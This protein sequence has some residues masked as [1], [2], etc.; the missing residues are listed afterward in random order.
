MAKAL[1]KD[2]TLSIRYA[3][4]SNG[5]APPEAREAIFKDIDFIIYTGDSDIF[6]P[7]SLECYPSGV[8]LLAI[9]NEN[10]KFGE[11]RYVPVNRS[12]TAYVTGVTPADDEDNAK[13]VEL[14]KKILVK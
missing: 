12:R 14:A 3:E 11:V 10:H 7:Q 1:A 6:H 2:K 4:L 5:Y 8:P 9:S 13:A